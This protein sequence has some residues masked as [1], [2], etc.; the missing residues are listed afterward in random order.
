VR[1]LLVCALSGVL[2]L[3]GSAFV[4]TSPRGNAATAAASCTYE[5]RQRRVDA[6]TRFRE[7]MAAQRARYFRR[8]RSRAK[9][10]AFVRRQERTLR[11]LR[12]AAACVVP[13]LPPSSDASCSFMLAP[14]EAAERGRLSPNSQGALFHEGANHPGDYLSAQGHVRALVL[15]VDFPDLPADQA[16]AIAG[17]LYF[18]ETAYFDEVSYGRFS[19]SAEAVDQWVRM[20]RPSAQYT[21]L[22]G[23]TAAYLGDAVAAADPLVDFSRYG[24]VFL[25]P[26]RRLLAGTTSQAI[27]RHPGRAFRADG[28]EVRFFALL[29]PDVVQYGRG[30]GYVSNHELMHTFGLPDTRN[31]PE[32]AGAWDAMGDR[33][34]IGPPPSTH[35]L[36]WHKWKIG[37]LEPGQLTCLTA[38]GVVDETLTPIAS[39]G[40]KKM[41]VV[42]TSPATTYVVEARRR[43]GY[44]EGVCQEGVLV[45]HVDSRPSFEPVD[46]NGPINLKGPKECDLAVAGA[47]QTGE[48]FEDA[49]IRVEVLA[50]DASAFRV[51]VTKK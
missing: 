19:L 12:T 38:P 36:G 21:P 31:S 23:H 37:W 33:S 13:P 50:R 20:P 34:G 10:R 25:V 22:S 29:Q 9:R 49:N 4:S 32:R 28:V 15:L 1:G 48:R 5:E 45:Y 6:L 27:V 8:N 44:D 2:I 51:R 3:C 39:R 14:N 17:P 46:G 24:F 11:S 35:L 26:T 41:V 30:A 16:A 43:I 40:G 47:F 42:P 18:P 7:A